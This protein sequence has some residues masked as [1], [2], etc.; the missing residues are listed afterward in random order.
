MVIARGHLAPLC[1]LLTAILV[2]PVQGDWLETFGTDGVN[3][4]RTWMYGAAPSG[5]FQ[6]SLSDAGGGDYYLNLLENKARDQGG[7]QI[8]AALCVDEV[9]ADVR[10][11]GTVN[12]NGNDRRHYMGLAARVDATEVP[13]MG[14]VVKSAYLLLYH[15]ED[16]P[17][18][19]R[20]ELIKVANN[21]DIRSSQPEYEVPGID[22]A[23]SHYLELEVLGSG[24]VYIRGSIYSYKGGPLLARTPVLVDTAGE[25]SWEGSDYGVYQGGISGVFV[26]NDRFGQDGFHATFDDV[27]SVGEGPRA[28][29]PSPADGAT[30]V[31]PDAVLSW[32]EGNFATSRRLWF[33]QD[34]ASQMYSPAGKTFDPVLE[35]GKTYK[36]R[37]DQLGA[38]GGEVVGH[39][40]TF[41]TAERLVV[42]DIESYKQNSPNKIFETWLDGW[43]VGNNGSIVGYTSSDP[44]YVETSTVYEGRYS[45]PFAYNT[46]GAVNYAEAT[47][48]TS[49]LKVG[50]NW[51]SGGA[52][53]LTLY[54]HGDRD[55]NDLQR[56]YVRLRD[57]FGTE[58]TVANPHAHA[59]HASSWER[60][61]I[62][63]SEF[64]DAGVD[65]SS[66]SSMTLGFGD[67]SG[68]TT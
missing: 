32:V 35:L 20:I 29:V 66:V 7:A 5:T 26:L 8:C 25:D 58:K 9:F 30:N 17:T 12:I 42:D 22:H 57:S 6:Q 16:G 48:D 51:T 24:P 53:M 46:G 39:T 11:G 2:Y 40:W 13:G 38:L 62:L 54:F 1:V 64:S 3:T 41:K 14:V 52:A 50:Q 34:Y 63:L 65:L 67:R 31:S 37:V 56:M 47:A 21:A 45:M 49:K 68:T 23:R 28:V 36:W 59:P 55:N 43:D 44:C 27:S 4:D 60:W 61:D 15:W 33:G 18:R 19:V 10:V